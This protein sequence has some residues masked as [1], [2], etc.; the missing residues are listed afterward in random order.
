VRLG[1]AAQRVRVLDDEAVRLVLE[2]TVSFVT[3][4]AIRRV[5]RALRL[6]Q[7][8]NSPPALVRVRSFS[9]LSDHTMQR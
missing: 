3:A 9:F 1:Q 5:L 4:S 6:R 7:E 2:A 8:S